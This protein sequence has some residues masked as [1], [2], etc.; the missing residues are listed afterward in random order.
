MAAQDLRIIPRDDGQQ[1]WWV[2]ENGR[3]SFTARTRD[4]AEGFCRRCLRQAR[5]D[6]ERLR[7]NAGFFG[8]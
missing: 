2:M 8:V 5:A 1:G 4:E 6:A 7:F 3:V